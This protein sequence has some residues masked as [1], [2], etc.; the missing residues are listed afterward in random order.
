M[1]KNTMNELM[2]IYEHVYKCTLRELNHSE[3]V[4]YAGDL[5]IIILRWSENTNF[6]IWIKFI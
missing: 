1:P 3:K 2:H 6:V 5:T 4:I